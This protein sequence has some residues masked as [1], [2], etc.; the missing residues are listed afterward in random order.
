MLGFIGVFWYYELDAVQIVIRENGPN[1]LQF[2]T[3]ICATMGGMWVVIGIFYSTTSA[4]FSLIF[5]SK[6]KE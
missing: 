3:R 1:F 5:P 2:V 6:K 4:I